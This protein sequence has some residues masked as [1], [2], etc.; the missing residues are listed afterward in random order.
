MA[1]RYPDPVSLGKGRTR[2]TW[3]NVATAD[4]VMPYEPGERSGLTGAVQ[5]TGTIT[6]ATLHKSNDGTNFVVC[7]DL[8]TSADMALT[9]AGMAE[10]STAALYLKPVVAGSGITVTLVLRS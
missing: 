5:F 1:D 4:T 7:R 8:G 9:A 3:T 2:V 10:I 6:S